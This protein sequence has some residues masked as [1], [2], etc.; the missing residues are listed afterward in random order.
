[1]NSAS[2][3]K[4][5]KRSSLFPEREL[6][7]QKPAVLVN[8]LISWTSI[9]FDHVSSSFSDSLFFSLFVLNSSSDPTSPEKI[10]GFELSLL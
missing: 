4:L 6:D 1:M 10:S 3:N 7:A 2:T 9:L 5:K 8:S